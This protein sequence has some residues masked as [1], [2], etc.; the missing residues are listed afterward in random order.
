M[1]NVS[2]RM[3]Q[4]FRT[5]PYDRPSQRQLWFL[6]LLSMLIHFH[7]STFKLLWV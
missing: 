2:M 6:L 3:I 5:T 4:L 1:A 7:A